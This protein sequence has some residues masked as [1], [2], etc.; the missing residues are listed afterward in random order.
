MHFKIFINFYKWNKWYMIYN[1]SDN[2]KEMAEVSKN[3]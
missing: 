1:D 2:T 3:R